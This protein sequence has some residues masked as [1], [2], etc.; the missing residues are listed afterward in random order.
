M[1]IENGGM[2]VQPVDGHCAAEPIDLGNLLSF[3]TGQQT[4]LQIVFVIAIDLA[5]GVLPDRIPLPVKKSEVGKADRSAVG[6]IDGAKGF[7]HA[8]GIAESQN[9]VVAPVQG[10]FAARESFL[11]QGDGLQHL[12][13]PAQGGE[14]IVVLEGEGAVSVPARPALD[15]RAVIV[16]VPGFGGIEGFG[17]RGGSGAALRQSGGILRLLGGTA[18]GSHS[19]QG[20]Q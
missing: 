11:R 15:Q 14:G 9:I 17:T 6:I 5:A 3:R 10:V 12:I 16:G 7:I 20:S 19:Q 13:L 2:S 1:T 8:G 18:R 4:D